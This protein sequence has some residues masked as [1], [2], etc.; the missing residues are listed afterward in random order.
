MNIQTIKREIQEF[1]EDYKYT[2][3]SVLMLL[4]LFG[5]HY[6]IVNASHNVY[7]EQMSL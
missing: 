1:R 3:F 7:D 6:T 2:I 5:T 4:F